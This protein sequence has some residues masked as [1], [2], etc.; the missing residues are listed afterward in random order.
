MLTAFSR[1]GEWRYYVQDAIVEHGAYL[2]QLLE[3]SAH[4]YFCDN[5]HNRENAIDQALVSVAGTFG[6][7]S[8]AAAEECLANLNAHGRIHKELY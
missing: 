6:Q 5:K 2:W 7:L 4:L 3:Q 8:H 1:D